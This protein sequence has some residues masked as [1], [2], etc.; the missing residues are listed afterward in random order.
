MRRRR[1]VRAGRLVD[2]F[3]APVFFGLRIFTRAMTARSCKGLPVRVAAAVLPFLLA[4]CVSAPPAPPTLSI[5]PFSTDG[6]S[7]FPDRALVGK[8]DWCHC[9]LE[10]DLA[11]WRGGTVDQR[12]KADQQLQACVLHASGN[13]ALADLML[14]GVRSGGGPYF[15]TTYR[16]AY[17]WPFGRNYEALSVDEQAAV[18]LL[19]QQYLAT[20]P[21]HA[22]TK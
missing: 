19:E 22:C 4:A 14:A 17:G 8:A 10:H 2:S 12:L 1:A 16:W 11:Y 9:C 5:Q 3:R 13:P 6:C 15:F 18:A 20:N 7:L 21:A